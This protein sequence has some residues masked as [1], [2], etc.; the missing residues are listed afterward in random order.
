MPRLTQLA[1][2]TPGSASETFVNPSMNFEAGNA[3]FSNVNEGASVTIRM[4]IENGAPT[5]SETV[6]YAFTLGAG[7]V[8]SADYSISSSGTIPIFTTPS[9]EFRTELNFTVTE[10]LTTEGGEDLTV[11]FSYDYTNPEHL[12][13]LH[14]F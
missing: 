2:I 14:I 5:T 13:F 1:G 9:G 10:D 8:E 4:K 11:T 3:N 6:S 12:V 7:F